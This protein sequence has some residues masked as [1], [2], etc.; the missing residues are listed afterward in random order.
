MGGGLP[1]LDH[2]YH[3]LFSRKIDHEI[4]TS[5]LSKGSYK[6]PFSGS[7]FVLRGVLKIQF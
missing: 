6:P 5:P 4:S 7:M 1:N 2:I 3:P